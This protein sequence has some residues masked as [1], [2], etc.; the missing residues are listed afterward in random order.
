MGPFAPSLLEWMGSSKAMALRIL[1]SPP[2][3]YVSP[4]AMCARVES[5]YPSLPL[6]GAICWLGVL[7][8][9]LMN[10]M[11]DIPACNERATNN[12]KKRASVHMHIFMREY[13]C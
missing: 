4:V 8:M 11:G 1:Q 9:L 13:M 3:G 7:F 6:H 2:P 5:Q 10:V 12:M